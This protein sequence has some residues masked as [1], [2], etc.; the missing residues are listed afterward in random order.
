[1]AT[2]VQATAAARGAVAGEAGVEE[3]CSGRKNEVSGRACTAAVQAVV[4]EAE[5]FAAALFSLLFMLVEVSAR[6]VSPYREGVCLV[7]HAQ[8]RCCDHYPGD[9]KEGPREWTW[10]NP[11]S[12]LSCVSG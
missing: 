2:I 8:G 11:G 10:R 6:G 12:V 3:F 1:M 4:E 9:K 7:C 5:V